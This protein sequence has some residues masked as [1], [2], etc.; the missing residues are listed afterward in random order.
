MQN[1]GSAPKKTDGVAVAAFVC[2]IACLLC[3]PLSLVTLA[4][5][6]L[7][8][9]ALATKKNPMWMPITALALS[10]VSILAEVL[11]AIFTFGTSLFI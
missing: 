9:V 11:C 1:P 6:I 5:I 10:G 8:I 4:A 7:S 3:N 2:G